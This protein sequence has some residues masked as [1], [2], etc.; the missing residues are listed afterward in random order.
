MGKSF[1]DSHGSAQKSGLEYIK[2][3][4]G[5]NKFRLVGDIRPRYAYWVDLNGN[6]IPIECLSFDPLEERFL[7]KEKDWYKHYFPNKKCVWSYVGQVIDDKD[8]TLKLC[9]LKKKLWDQVMDASKKLGD[10]TDLKKG[11][12][13]IVDKKKTGPNKFNVE[14]ALQVLDCQNTIGP[15]TESEM[16]LIKNLKPI[17]ELVIRPTPEDQKDFIEQNLLNG[18]KPEN[19]TNSEAVSEFENDVPF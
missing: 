6:S 2:L 17:D 19:N 3:D 5:I 18:N 1:N 8:K 9:G 10:P 11:W 4:W 7:N 13:F 15:L 12:W 16:E 14:Y